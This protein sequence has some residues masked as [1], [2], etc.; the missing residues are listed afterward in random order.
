MSS[1]CRVA[2]EGHATRLPVVAVAGVDLWRI[3]LDWLPPGASALLTADERARA[4]RFVFDRDRTRFVAGRAAVRLLLADHAGSAPEAL[5]FELGPYGKPHL[6][7]GPPFSYS[8]SGAWGLLA[9]GGDRPLGVDLEQLREVEDAAAVA[10][11]AFGREDLAAW[12][13]G[14]SDPREG[15]LRVWTRKEATLKALGLGLAGEGHIA[16]EMRSAVE[17][18]DVDFDPD[19]AAAL[20]V[21]RGPEPT[22]LG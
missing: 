21:L 17:V 15:F 14:G 9:L 19:H 20:A 12:Q 6:A 16:A 10:A 4:G 22:R 18:F 2:L 7:A 11:G 5:V 1:G 13:A 8:N 3:D